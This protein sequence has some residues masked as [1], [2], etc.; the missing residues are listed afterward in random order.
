MDIPS[1]LNHTNHLH[2]TPQAQRFYYLHSTRHTHR[3]AFS[4]PE[5]HPRQPKAK[6]L[7][8]DDKLEIR[9]LR[10]HCKWTYQ[11]ISQTTG[12]T[13][14]QVQDALRGN[15]TPRKRGSKVGTRRRPRG[16]GGEELLKF[17]KPVVLRPDGIGVYHDDVSGYGGRGDGEN[18]SPALPSPP[19]S[20]SPLPSP[21]PSPSPRIKLEVL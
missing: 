20:P 18:I 21:S 13:I 11:Q 4:P 9:T 3:R 14:H 2:S 5:S 8:R 19:A 15:L 16:D 7:T 1:L 17:R 10:K 6:P 12:K